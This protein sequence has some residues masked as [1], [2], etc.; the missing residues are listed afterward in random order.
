MQNFHEQA[1]MFRDALALTRQRTGFVARLIEKDYFCTLLLE[2]LA[3]ASPELVFKGG[4]CLAKIHAD[5][6][7][8]SEDLDF[9]IPMSVSGEIELRQNGRRGMDL[10]RRGFSSKDS[11][12]TLLPSSPA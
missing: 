5:F 12:Q 10:L 1:E 9:V 11:Q 4:T 2:Y 7:R 8:L 6:Y 3:E